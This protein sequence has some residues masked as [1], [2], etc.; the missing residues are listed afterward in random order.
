MGAQGVGEDGGAV[1][2]DEEVGAGQDQQDVGL[3]QAL[4]AGGGDDVAGQQVVAARED[5]GALLVQEPEVRV[6]L[7]GEG[8]VLG[9]EEQQ[10]AAGIGELELPAAGAGGLAPVPAVFCRG[11]C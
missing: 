8:A 5:H 2:A 6:Q 3:A 4:G 10:H 9:V 11:W 1:F 7:V